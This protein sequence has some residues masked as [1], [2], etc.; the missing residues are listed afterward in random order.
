MNSSRI[1]SLFLLALVALMVGLHA[2]RVSA[3]A[4]DDMRLSWF[5][6]L[7]G[8]TDYDATDPD[9]VAATVSLT[10]TAQ[11]YWTLLDA[12]KPFAAN[13]TPFSDMP[14]GTA[15]DN[16]SV[17]YGRLE[18]MTKAYWAK[19]GALYQNADLET[20]IVSTLDW[21]NDNIYNSNTKQYGNWFAWLIGVPLALNDITVMFHDT[22]TP[23]EISNY[24]GAVDHFMYS[25]TQIGGGN[26][27]NGAW[28]TIIVGVRAL[29]VKDPV[30]LAAASANF[31]T[32]AALVTAP[33]GFFADGSNI[34]HGAFSYT[35]GYGLSLMQ[36]VSSGYY[37]F[38]PAALDPL[39]TDKRAAVY[40][41]VFNSYQSLMYQGKLPY[42]SVGR[43]ISRGPSDGQGESV[44]DICL[45]MVG[46]DT[47]D[48]AA[49]VRAFAKHVF[50]AS[51]S[52][53]SGL[54]SINSVIRMKG[55]MAD[56]SIVA[57]VD[58]I[59]TRVFPIMDKVTS[60][61]PGFGVDVAYFSKHTGNYESINGENLKGWHQ[62]DGM[63]Y[64]DNADWNQ[65]NGTFWA[66]WTASGC[67]ARR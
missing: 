18:T 40:G 24:T 45:Q 35:A 37:L 60:V 7:T 67:R 63:T 43:A 64:L 50:T 17:I 52:N 29:I 14:L 28:S 3:D 1:R 22:L 20:D 16:L 51:G 36:E 15:S 11:S 9:V 38:S 59:G 48:S 57:A 49:Q 41:W 54:G 46:S 6:N 39:P 4:F 27:A 44:S 53:Y 2:P 19:G 58:P 32:L 56:P 65:Y 30:K 25:P 23:T 12:S 8:G 31:S 26:G 34:G 13:G 42:Y 62:T 55:V 47:S 61:Q 33:D 5:N 10:N 66:R 21:L